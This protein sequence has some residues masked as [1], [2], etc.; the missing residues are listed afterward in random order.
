MVVLE[1]ARFLMSE[2]PLHSTGEGTHFTQVRTLKEGRG[3]E[4][5]AAEVPLPTRVHLS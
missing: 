5:R 4:L 1:G 2:V 3:I